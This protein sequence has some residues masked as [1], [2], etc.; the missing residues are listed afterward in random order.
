MHSLEGTLPMAAPYLAMSLQLPH[1]PTYNDQQAS[2]FE[3]GFQANAV[4][5][6]L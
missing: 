1:E 5:A 6:G 4:M 3:F 2:L